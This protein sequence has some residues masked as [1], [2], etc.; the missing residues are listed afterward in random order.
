MVRIVVAG[1][2]SRG[3]STLAVHWREQCTAREDTERGSYSVEWRHRV[4]R[5][6][7]LLAVACEDDSEAVAV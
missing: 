1:A 3:R 4:E 6:G 5:R 7:T 2:D